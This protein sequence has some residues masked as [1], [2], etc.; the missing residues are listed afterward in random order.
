MSVATAALLGL[1]PIGLDELTA[2]AALLTRLDRKY[3]VPVEQLDDLLLALEPDA[4][5]LDVDGLRRFGYE[6]VYFDTPALVCFHAAAGGR[7]RRY[8]VRT[9]TYLD[10]GGCYV[11]VKT[12][13]PRGATVKT[14]APYA[15]HERGRLTAGGWSFAR[16]ALDEARVPVPGGPEPLAAALVSRYDRVTFFLP[17]TG[18]RATVDTGLTWTTPGGHDERTM[19]GVAVVETKTGAAPSSLDRLLWRAGHRPV[20]LSK[21]GTGMAALHPDLPAT[22]WRRTL[23]RHVLP[24]GR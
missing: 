19:P 24:A 9:R 3:V 6:S 7:R 1:E 22:R 2:R 14:R 18:A 4:R 10:T 16:G 21:Y 5:V 11:E 8:K 13:G 12:R 23:D 15:R 20:R 17:S